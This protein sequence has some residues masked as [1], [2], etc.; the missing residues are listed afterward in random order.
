MTSISK[1]LSKDDRWE[2]IELNVTRDILLGFA[3]KLYALKGMHRIFINAKI[4][5]S[6]FG[7]GASIEKAVPANDIE[8]AITDMLELCKKQGKRILVNIDEATNSEYIRQFSYAFQIFLR[9]D[10]PVFLIMTGLYENIYN[11]QNDKSLTFLYRAPKI[12]LEPLNINA[13]A[14]KYANIFGVDKKNAYKMAL[15]TKGYP[16]AFQVMGYLYYENGGDIDGLLT[17]Y[18]QYL[19]EYVYDK[20]WMEL[21]SLDKKVMITISS[22]SKNKVKDIREELGMNPSQFSVYRD[23]LIRKGLIKSGEYGTVELTLP[24]FEVF[25]NKRKYIMDMEI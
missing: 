25:V 19:E 9:Q 14:D 23:R 21:S 8:T 17:K 5:L 16:F 12:M 20:I 7:I 3:S 2:T 1:E 15:L 13:I 10:L 18:D 22:T 24:R 4:D 11:L 6:L